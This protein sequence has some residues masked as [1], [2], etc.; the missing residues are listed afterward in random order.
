[1]RL[2]SHMTSEQ[3]TRVSMGHKGQPAWNKGKPMSDKTRAKL[4]VAMIGKRAGFLS[5]LWKGGPETWIRKANAKRR[6]FGFVPLNEPFAGSEAHHVDPEQAIYVPKELHRSIYH[7]QHTGQ[8][9]A[10]MNAIVYNFLFKQEVEA[11]MAAK[12]QHEENRD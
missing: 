8:G 6:T 12:E 5:P 11:A 7:N 4:S 10:Q 3:R 9:M 1:M 2:G